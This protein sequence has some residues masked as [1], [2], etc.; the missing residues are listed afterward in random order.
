MLGL[1]SRPERR[2][3]G[4]SNPATL[5]TH[6][7]TMPEDQAPVGEKGTLFAIWNQTGDVLR[8]NQ[9]VRLVVKRVGAVSN[10]WP[11]CLI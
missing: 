9:S 5:I 6:H 1:S 2:A 4:P 10:G 3:Y 8:Q 11:D 7:L